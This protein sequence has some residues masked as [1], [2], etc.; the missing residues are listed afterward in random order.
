MIGVIRK[1]M[2]VRSVD[3]IM[4]IKGKWKNA[5]R[6]ARNTRAAI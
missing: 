6:G 4:K 3:Y 1:P 5:K 2:S